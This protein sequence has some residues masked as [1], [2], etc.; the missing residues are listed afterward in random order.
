MPI[1]SKKQPWIGLFPI[2]QNMYQGNSTNTFADT[3]ICSD[4]A[5]VAFAFN[6]VLSNNTDLLHY[7]I[8][9]Y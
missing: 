9:F 7:L 2:Y 4:T 6:L 3:E 8:K 5:E 1:K